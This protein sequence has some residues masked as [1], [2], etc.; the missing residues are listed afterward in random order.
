[1]KSQE[2]ILKDNKQLNVCK[3]LLKIT[4]NLYFSNIDIKKVV[5]NSSFWKTVSPFVFTK[6]SKCDKITFN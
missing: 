6:Y 3:K 1:M 4:K 2:H 5:D